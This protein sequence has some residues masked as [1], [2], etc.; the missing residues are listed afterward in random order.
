[1]TS[2][3]VCKQRRIDANVPQVCKRA[4]RNCETRQASRDHLYRQILVEIFACET[5]SAR[6][7]GLLVWIV[8]L[9]DDFKLALSH[10]DLH[11]LSVF[12]LDID[13]QD[14]DPDFVKDPLPAIATVGKRDHAQARER[15]P[16]ADDRMTCE[17][18][19]TSG[20]EDTQASQCFVCF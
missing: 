11:R 10:D 4:D 13:R 9:V 8:D 18:D 1:V 6:D 15:S 5:K 16:C 3:N 2:V 7:L 14:S 17:R 19:L 12:K 20:R